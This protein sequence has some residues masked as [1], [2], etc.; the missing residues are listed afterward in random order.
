MHLSRSDATV[1][2]V[3]NVEFHQSSGLNHSGQMFDS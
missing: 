1:G 2:L 3:S